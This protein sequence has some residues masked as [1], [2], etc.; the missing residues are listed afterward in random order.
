MELVIDLGL[1][2]LDRIYWGG[3]GVSDLYEHSYTKRLIELEELYPKILPETP[4]RSGGG[5]GWGFCPCTAKEDDTYGDDELEMKSP[6]YRQKSPK[7]G[8]QSRPAPLSPERCVTI[9]HINYMLPNI[10]CY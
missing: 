3:G 8:F 9:P 1:D 5:G 7:I 10:D 2:T 4:T 6:N